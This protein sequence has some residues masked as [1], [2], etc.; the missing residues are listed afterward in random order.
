MYKELFNAGTK[1]HGSTAPYLADLNYASE[2]GANVTLANAMK[3]WYI[4]FAIHADPNFE[5]WSETGKPYWPDYETGEVM[6]I[7]DTDTGAVSDVYYDD[8]ARCQFFWD[9]NEVVQN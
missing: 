9:N 6:S 8:S 3:D 1:L 5:S 2:P 4:S 7:N